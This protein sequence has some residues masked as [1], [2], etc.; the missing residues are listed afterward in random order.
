[1]IEYNK[2]ILLNKDFLE[3]CSAKQNANAFLFESEDNVFLKSF[4]LSYAKHL[5]C[6]N[7][8]N[9]VVCDCCQNCVKVNALSHPDMIIYPKGQKN[10][11]VD[12][13]KELIDFSYLSSAEADKKVFVL[14]DFSKATQQAQNKL[15]KILEEPPKNVYIILCV[16]NINNVLR[17]IVS[18]CNRYQL[19]KLEKQE[20]LSCIDF[21]NFNQNEIDEI[22]DLAQG[23][24]EKALKYSANTLFLQT[25]QDCLTT[26]C[27]MC[28][29]TSL[30]IYSSK[31]SVTKE[32][33]E[34]ALEIFENIFHD[35][36]LIRLNKASLIKNKNNL[37]VIEK[38]A[39]QYDSD[40]IDKIIKK[41]YLIKKQIQFNCSYVLLADSFLLYILEVRF[42]CN[43]K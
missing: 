13:I 7:K 33:F 19:H 14:F 27:D 25:Y 39:R 32:K 31:I 36:L 43:K 12:D 28:D 40:A 20:M 21:K 6:L 35:M 24:L 15:L 5:L 16:S 17:T 2:Q 37:D 3:I 11:S 42:L 30:V 1:M 18:R 26:L 34:F 38:L 41:I 23:S 8:S 9:G 29:S 4:A 22:L 10:I